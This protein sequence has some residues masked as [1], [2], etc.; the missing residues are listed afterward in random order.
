MFCFLGCLPENNCQES[1]HKI[2]KAA[3]KMYL[4]G[5]TFRCI[6]LAIPRLA[7]LDSLKMG[8]YLSM[9]L[10]IVKN[11]TLTKALYIE[12]KGLMMIFSDTPDEFFVLRYI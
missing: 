1:W 11:K 8:T 6:D 9:D 4:R 7:K 10:Q 12:Q 5:S 2:A 3:I